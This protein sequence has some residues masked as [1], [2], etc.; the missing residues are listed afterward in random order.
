MPTALPPAVTDQTFTAF[1]KL[2][3]EFVD[4]EERLN[5]P[6]HRFLIALWRKTGG[7]NVPETNNVSLVQASSGAIQAY[8][9]N[10]TVLGT[11]ALENKP[12]GAAQVIAPTASP[13]VYAALVGGLLLV[14]SGKLELS[15]DAGVTYYIV[16]LQGGA[17]PLKNGDKARITS[18]S[19][20]TITWFPD[21][22]S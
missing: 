17:L 7:S 8:D 21:F 11:V 14:S 13:Q 3:T 15:R 20:T 10:G 6:W 18:N 12:G 22:T 16:G 2:S 5:A 9:Q 19:A 4:K 1:P